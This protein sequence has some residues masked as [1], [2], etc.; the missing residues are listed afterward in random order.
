VNEL[1]TTLSISVAF[2]YIV[3]GKSK[4][5]TREEKKAKSSQTSFL[6]PFKRGRI[7]LLSRICLPASFITNISVLI[8]SVPDPDSIRAPDPEYGSGSRRAKMTHKNR[9]N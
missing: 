5:R 8:R 9:K 6:Q 2:H 1:G 7:D 4:K 3:L